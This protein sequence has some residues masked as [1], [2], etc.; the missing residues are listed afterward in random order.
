MKKQL[1]ILWIGIGLVV[2]AILF[3]PWMRNGS[4]HRIF[5]GYGFLFSPPSEFTSIES[6]RLTAEILIIVLLTAGAFYTAKV[7]PSSIKFLAWG[8]AV[9]IAVGVV[10]FA[11]MLLVRHWQAKKVSTAIRP[12]IQKLLDE[13]DPYAD[14]ATI[15]P[16]QPPPPVVYKTIHEAA[17]QGD[18]AAVKICLQKGIG[19]IG[20]DERDHYDNTP[21]MDAA[22]NGQLDVVKYLVDNGANVNTIDKA[23]RTPLMLAAEKGHLDVVKY[24]VDKGAMNAQNCAELA[25]KN[26][27]L[28]VVEFLVT[29]GTDVNARGRNGT[30]PLMK[31]AG[32]GQLDVVK[33]LVDKGADVNAKGEDGWTPLMMAMSDGNL[34]IVKVLVEKGADVNAKYEN[35]LTVLM[36]AAAAGKLDMVKFLVDKGADVNAMINAGWWTPLRY[37]ADKGHL[38]VVE[39]LKQH[40]AKE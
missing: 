2:L 24:L 20:V 3:P 37:A 1:I 26:G 30:M 15:V 19:V 34:D 13:T 32:L 36:Y 4:G 10:T 33:Y 31:A 9:V 8:V 14:I 39:F 23:Y 27:Y 21:L 28:D 22:E 6:S 5:E 29:K 11:G 12:E 38:N 40:G 18:L 16:N 7:F 25:A 17:K 35:G